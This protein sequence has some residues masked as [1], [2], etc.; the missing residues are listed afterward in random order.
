MSWGPLHTPWP[1]ALPTR[2]LQVEEHPRRGCQCRSCQPERTRTCQP[3]WAVTLLVVLLGRLASAW[4]GA[5][6]GT[7][8]WGPPWRTRLVRSS[9]QERLCLRDRF[10]HDEITTS[11]RGRPGPASLLPRRPATGAASYCYAAGTLPTFVGT[12]S[13]NGLVL[14]WL[15][16][17]VALWHYHSAWPGCQCSD[18]ATT[19]GNLAT[20]AP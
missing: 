8:I 6:P 2:S 11:C 7:G 9:R 17:T 4:R 1:G 10:Y 19:P 5:S 15:G 13:T 12:T 18:P 20:K 3:E 16:T 14:R